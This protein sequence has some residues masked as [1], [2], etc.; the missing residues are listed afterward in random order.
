MPQVRPPITLLVI[1]VGENT[2]FDPSREEIAVADAVLAISVARDGG[3][4]NL[5][6]LSIRTIDSPSRL[7]QPGVPNSENVNALGATAPTQDV[8]VL[9]PATGEEEVPGVW[10]PRRGGVKRGV[11]AQMVKTVLKKGGVGEEVLEGLE[12]V[13][14]E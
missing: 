5:K 2:I 9:N 12:G 6:L 10:R 1:S 14:V 3:D 4:K 7:T 11:I 13:E 8:A